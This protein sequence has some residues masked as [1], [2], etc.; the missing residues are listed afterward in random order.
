MSRNLQRGVDNKYRGSAVE[1]EINPIHLG[2]HQ[3]IR[4]MQNY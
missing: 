2:L 4:P 3:I 1:Q